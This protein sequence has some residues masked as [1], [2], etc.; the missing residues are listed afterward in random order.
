MGASNETDLA[1]RLADL[2][3]C[4]AA[5][6]ATLAAEAA[7]RRYAAGATIVHQGAV[8]DRVMLLLAGRAR[9]AMVTLDGRL[10]H[11]A[12]H[13]PGAIFGGVDAGREQPIDVTATAPS[14]VASFATAAF[15]G[16][17]EQH[18]CVGLVLARAMVRQLDA[19]SQLVSA[20]LTLSAAGRVH[21]EL[22]RLAREGEEGRWI[23]PAPV[24]S[25]L[26]IRVQAARETV[27]RA[28]SALER[29]GILRRHDDALEIV[30]PGRLEALIV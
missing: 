17:A 19:M 25:D 30:A 18:A 2:F 11:V 12:D 16:L 7:V 10:L 28:V 27:S 26:A 9:A 21:A 1:T 14:L 5:L 6:G 23:R 8:S 4:D 29:R 24:L 20:R 22:L 3:A 13:Q 15:Y